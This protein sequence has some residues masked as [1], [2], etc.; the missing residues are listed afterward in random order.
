MSLLVALD[1]AEPR[2]VRMTRSGETATLWIDG[3]SC[4]ARVGSGNGAVQLTVEGRTESVWVVTE[5]DQVHVHAFG[6]SWTLEVTDP[7]ER[8]LRAVQG[9]DAATA[10]M[11]G[12]LVSLSVQPG[13]DV[14]AGQQL[15]VIESMKL[16]SEITAWRDGRVARVMVEV[17]DSFGQGAPLVALEPLENDDDPEGGPA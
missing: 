6:R 2:E 4:A 8:S 15:A 3:V 12:V 17:G 1:G 14:V 16:H 7:V 9:S 11:P 5:R 10:P 13:D